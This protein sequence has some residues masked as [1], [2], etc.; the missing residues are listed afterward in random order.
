MNNLARGSF[1]FLYPFDHFPKAL[2]EV[3]L[4]LVA[5][6][7]VCPIPFVIVKNLFSQVILYRRNPV[8]HSPHW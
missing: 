5:T 7:R 8:A 1:N 3:E 6:K 2:A 4:V